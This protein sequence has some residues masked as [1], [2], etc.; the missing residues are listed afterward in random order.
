MK[1]IGINLIIGTINS[2]IL[3]ILC[4]LVIKPNY[5]YL[6]VFDGKIFSS[7]DYSTFSYE[8]E[9]S[10]YSKIDIKFK[11]DAEILRI[12]SDNPDDSIGKF[13]ISYNYSTYETVIL[14]EGKTAG[15]TYKIVNGSP[16]YTFEDTDSEKI[17]I[18]IKY[19]SLINVKE[20]NNDKIN[21]TTQ[22]I[23]CSILSI[24]IGFILS[25]LAYP[26]ILYEK[27][28][29]NRKLA[30]ISGSMT[31][32]LCLFSAFYIYFTIK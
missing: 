19:T 5:T 3:I 11:K 32:I 9:D 24:F 4:I 29:E 30:C 15:G 13:E 26:V 14:A 8:N 20:I 21:V 12:S 16:V 28:K 2:I 6:T 31:I 27:V 1:K 7:T 23:I 18:F 10:K 25:F 17:A 22:K